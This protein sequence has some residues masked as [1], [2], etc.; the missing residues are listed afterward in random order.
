MKGIPLILSTTIFNITPPCLPIQA[1]NTM[2][3]MKTKLN[4]KYCNNTLPH[5]WHPAK[6]ISYNVDDSTTI[7]LHP[8]SVGYILRRRYPYFDFHT[9]YLKQATPTPPLHRVGMWPRPVINCTSLC[10][11]LCLTIYV[12]VRHLVTTTKGAPY[13]VN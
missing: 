1:L 2:R 11:L 12:R 3:E 9:P 7:L 13:F 10:T 5:D 6:I 4:E 8:G